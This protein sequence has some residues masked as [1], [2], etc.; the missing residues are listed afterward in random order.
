VCC[1]PQNGPAAVAILEVEANIDLL[2]T[3][4]I[5]PGGMDGVALARYAVD[6]FPGIKVLYA[7]GYAEETVLNRDE[8]DAEINWIS[9][10][11]RKQDLERTVRGILESPQEVP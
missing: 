9:K 2:F 1:G 7:S 10:P 8:H 4:I 11:Y 5:M 6:R 3:D